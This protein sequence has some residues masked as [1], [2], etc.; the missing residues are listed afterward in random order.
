MNQPF[1]TRRIILAA[2]EQRAR[3]IALLANVP[4]GLEVLIRKPVKVRGLD[5]NGYYFMRIGEIAEQA[6]IDGKQF[7]KD[8][9]HE[10]AKK[11]ILPEEVTTKDGEVRSKWEQ[12]P[13]G[14]MSVIS[15]TRLERGCFADYTTAVEAFGAS[16]GVMFSVNPKGNNAN[17]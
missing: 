1:E 10:Y 2:E 9:W 12:T 13:D 15:T 6:W 14:G 16:L 5:Q 11:N 8:A 17:Q 4:L 7:S 3:A